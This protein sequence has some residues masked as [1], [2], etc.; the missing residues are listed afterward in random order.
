MFVV[1]S[2]VV[3]YPLRCMLCCSVKDVKSVVVS[4]K[5]KYQ[6]QPDKSVIQINS[7][8]SRVNRVSEMQQGVDWIDVTQH[9][10]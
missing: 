9:L 1:Y 10:D 5:Y 8:F 6:T 3:C 2:L 4:S 7:A